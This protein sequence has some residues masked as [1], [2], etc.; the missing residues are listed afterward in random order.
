MKNID[1]YKKMWYECQLGN[2]P[3]KSQ[4]VK[5]NNYRSKY[6]LQHGALALMTEIIQIALSLISKF[7]EYKCC[8]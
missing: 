6:D 4:F 2:S 1:R 3:T 5:V 7:L 8:V